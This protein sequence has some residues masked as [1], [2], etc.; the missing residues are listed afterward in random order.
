MAYPSVSAGPDAA[1]GR[2]IEGAPCPAARPRGSAADVVPIGPNLYATLAS[3]IVLLVLP[4]PCL[5][6]LLAVWAEVIAD[7]PVAGF[8]ILANP[9]DSLVHAAVGAVLFLII[10][11]VLQTWNHHRPFPS[12]IPVLLAFPVAWGLIVP[13]SLA[14]G[15]SFLSGIILGSAIALAFGVHWGALRFLNEAID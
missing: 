11:A 13:E 8:L 12:R 1:A 6:I 9:L 15:G 14:N 10:A 4:W 7:D 5:Y 2:R 3:F